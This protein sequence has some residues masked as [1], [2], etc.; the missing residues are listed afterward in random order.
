MSLNV[1]K[2]SSLP[3]TRRLNLCSGYLFLVVLIAT[4]VAEQ[5]VWLSTS[6]TIQGPRNDVQKKKR[7]LLKNDQWI[8]RSGVQNLTENKDCKDKPRIFWNKA[9]AVSAAAWTWGCEVKDCLFLL[10]PQPPGSITSPYLPRAHPFQPLDGVDSNR[11][12]GNWNW[13]WLNFTP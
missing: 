11:R 4:V 7:Y 9:G 8:Q 2:F 5:N 6:R 3:L 1:I 12:K 10:R 13:N